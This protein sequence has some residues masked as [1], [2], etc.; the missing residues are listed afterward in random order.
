MTCA[1]A[2]LHAPA[3]WG[4]DPESF[5]GPADSG[6]HH[7]LFDWER[8]ALAVCAACPVQA[9]CLA[10]ALG[11]PADE[12]HGVIGATTAAQRRVLLRTAGRRPSRTSVEEDPNVTAARLA[13]AGASARQIAK[14]LHLNERRVQ[15]WLATHRAEGVA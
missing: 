8:R 14:Q 10:A 3:C 6:E 15:R 11:F 9:A 1:K 12:Q 7:P 13:A 4:A 2:S 5:F